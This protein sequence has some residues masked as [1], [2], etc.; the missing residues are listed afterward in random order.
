MAIDMNVTYYVELDEWTGY[1]TIETKWF[2][3]K[4]LVNYEKGDN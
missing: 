1:N 3:I 2:A 4:Y